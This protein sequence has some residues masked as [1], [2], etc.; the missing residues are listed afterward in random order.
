MNADAPNDQRRENL[1]LAAEEV[2]SAAR[3]IRAT[4]E[5]EQEENMVNA[6][7]DHG[8]GLEEIHAALRLT[9]DNPPPPRKP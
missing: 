4:A 2:R 5:T 9:L 1:S 7:E 8:A 3:R 6:L